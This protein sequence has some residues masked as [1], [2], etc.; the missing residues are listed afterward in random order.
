L[1]PNSSSESGYWPPSKIQPT[2]HAAGNLTERYREGV[3]WRTAAQSFRRKDFGKLRKFF[4]RSLSFGEK[5]YAAAPGC[6]RFSGSP[7]FSADLM[8]LVLIYFAR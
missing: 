1:R 4:S 8:V 5:R 6:V 2:N 3:F 7:V